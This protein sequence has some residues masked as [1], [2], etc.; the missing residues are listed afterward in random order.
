MHHKIIELDMDGVLVNLDA[1]IQETA[2]LAFGQHPAKQMWA[3]LREH[4]HD[5]FRDAE[6]MPDAHELVR[7]VMGMRDRGFRVEILTAVPLFKSFPHAKAHKREWLQKHFPELAGPGFKIGP[8]SRDKWRHAK[9]GNI[10]IDDRP[11]NIQQ[12]RAAGGIGILHVSA[13]RS[14]ADL[15][16]AVHQMKKM[17]CA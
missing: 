6:P 3:L 17:M 13:A 1:H 10:L 9:P 15:D 4:C 5:M 8:F 16:G 7:H 12:W 11:M 14:I 2:G